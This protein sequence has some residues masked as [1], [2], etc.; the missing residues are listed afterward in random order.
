MRFIESLTEASS[1][2]P[3]KKYHKS[4]SCVRHKPQAAHRSSTFLDLGQVLGLQANTQT[5]PVNTIAL[6]GNKKL[7]TWSNEHCAQSFPHSQS[8]FFH[9]NS[10][11]LPSRSHLVPEASISSA[12]QFTVD[13]ASSKAE[14]WWK[15]GDEQ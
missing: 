10:F 4:A 7:H 8:L 12:W 13:L 14:Q 9:S 3:V 11:Q 5:F 1:R 15:Q 2:S 6:L